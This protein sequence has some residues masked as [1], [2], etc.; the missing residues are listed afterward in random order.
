MTGH[1]K[2]APVLSMFLVKFLWNIFKADFS[3]IKRALYSTDFITSL[4][5]VFSKSNSPS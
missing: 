4:P 2:R 5:G 3:Q 1:S